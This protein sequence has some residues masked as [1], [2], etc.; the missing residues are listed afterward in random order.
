M[1]FKDF[2]APVL[3]KAAPVLLEAAPVLPRAAP[4]TGKEQMSSNLAAVSNHDRP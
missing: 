3:L 4:G 2:A 1:I